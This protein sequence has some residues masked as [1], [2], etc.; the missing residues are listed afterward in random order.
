MQEGDK[1]KMIFITKFSTYEFNV[2]P[3]GSCNA[4]ATFQRLMD[5]VLHEFKDKFVVVYLDDITVYS[6]TFNDH[7]QH[8]I[9]TNY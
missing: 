6:E 8:L 5:E 1:K 9:K 4:P 2:L 7:M 3:F